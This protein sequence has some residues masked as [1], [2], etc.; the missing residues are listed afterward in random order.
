M[1]QLDRP[2]GVVQVIP[3]YDQDHGSLAFTVVVM[4]TGGRAGTINTVDITGAAG[5]QKLAVFTA[6]ELQKKA[7]NR[8]MW[9]QIGLAVAGGLAA[10][11]AA[12]ARDHYH[13]KLVTPHGTYRYRFSAPSV[14]GRIAAAAYTAN[15]EYGIARI[16]DQL[17]ETRA[18]IGGN[19]FQLTTIDPGD[20]Y[21]G[22]VVLTKIKGLQPPQ[23]V[24]LTV[25]WQ[26]VEYPFAFMVGKPGMAVPSM[27]VLEAPGAPPTTLVS[28]PTAPASTPGPT[29]PAVMAASMVV[30]QPAP[31]VFLSSPVAPVEPAVPVPPTSNRLSSANIA[32]Q[33]VKLSDLRE[34]GDISNTEFEKQKAALLAQ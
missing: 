27:K 6:D 25:R 9:S 33:L 8:A 29:T 32:Q 18:A 24:A 20:S 22:R 17:K 30:P 1:V 12:N 26:G 11:G 19:S 31:A 21:A 15:T 23:R 14:S 10:A 4:N 2:E 16:Q 5:S 3:A 13:S 28:A 7:S 34:S